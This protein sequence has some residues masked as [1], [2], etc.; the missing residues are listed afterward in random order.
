MLAMDK[1]HFIR[2]LYYEQGKDIPT[3]IAE[4]GHDRK[5]IVKYLDMTDFNLPEP[6]PSDP[7][8]ICPKLDRFKPVIDGWLI[9]DKKY[10]RKQRHTAKRVLKRLVKEVEGF[11]CSYRL[12]EY[13]GTMKP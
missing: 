4:T 13:S 11:D 6:Q 10:Y 8:A 12:V 1:V 5:T 3:I 7:E 2:Q 9:E